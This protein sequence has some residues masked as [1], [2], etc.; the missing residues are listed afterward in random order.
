[1][2]L[3][4]GRQLIIIQ[5]LSI[6]VQKYIYIVANKFFYVITKNKNQNLTTLTFFRK[7]RFPSTK[8]CLVINEDNLVCT[9]WKI[10]DSLNIFSLSLMTSPLETRKEH[11]GWYEFRT[12]E[13]MSCEYSF[14]L[15]SKANSDQ[16]A[17]SNHCL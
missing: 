4:L 5:N 16:K 11:N 2:N 7:L 14:N 13:H 8:R 17:N 1:M 10:Y 3:N 6:R 12:Q 9:S 15:N